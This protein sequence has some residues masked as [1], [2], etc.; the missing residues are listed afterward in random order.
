MNENKSLLH[1]PSIKR[2]LEGKA[3]GEHMVKLYE[4]LAAEAAL[5]EEGSIDMAVIYI[6]EDD[7]FEIGTYVP[8]LHLTLRKVEADP[9]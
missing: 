3:C 8:E 1:A 4:T 7:E 6:D 9:E 5:L 2:I